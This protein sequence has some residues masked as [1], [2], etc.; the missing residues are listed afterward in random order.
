MILTS[1]N[2]EF[3]LQNLTFNTYLSTQT[4]EQRCSHWVPVV[5][6]S[7]HP[8]SMKM[9]SKKTLLAIKPEFLIS[10]FVKSLPHPEPLVCLLRFVLF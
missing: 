5:M 8:R 3:T 1:D 6:L 9:E 7:A 4:N 10:D 2:E